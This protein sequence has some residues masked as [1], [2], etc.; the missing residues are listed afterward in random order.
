VA[1]EV[2]VLVEELDP[3]RTSASEWDGE[4]VD[5]DE[6][7][8]EGGIEAEGK[9]LWKPRSPVLEDWASP[10]TPFDLGLELMSS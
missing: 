9:K 8:S 2:S 4:W 6:K 10:R 3:D 1:A 5:R 7:S